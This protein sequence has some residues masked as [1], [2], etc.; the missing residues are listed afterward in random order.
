MNRTQLES[1][2][3]QIEAQLARPPQSFQGDDWLLWNAMANLIR[4]L[5][6]DAH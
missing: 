6:A 3:K 1:L 2:L 4:A 5:M